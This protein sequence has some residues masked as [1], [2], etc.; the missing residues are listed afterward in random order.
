MI[1]L[2]GEW[3]Q[4]TKDSVISDALLCDNASTACVTDYV[5]HLK[6]K[7]NKQ[8]GLVVSHPPYLNCFD[9]IPV[10]KLEFMWTTGFDDLFF[11][12]SYKEIKEMEIKSYPASSS[13]NI[14]NYF[15]HNRKVYEAVLKPSTWWILLY[16][17]W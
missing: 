9:Y 15:L 5:C 3:N 13:E 2:M 17:N 4:V 8:L 7:T 12:Y 11:G 6:E 14:E 10:Y 16:C 1:A